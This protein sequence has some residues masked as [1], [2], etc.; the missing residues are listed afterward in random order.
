MIADIGEVFK[1]IIMIGS[2]KV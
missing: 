1:V 2:F